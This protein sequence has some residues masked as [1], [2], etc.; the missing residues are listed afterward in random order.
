M[1]LT[2]AVAIR[3]YEPPDL[4]VALGVINAAARSYRAFLPP[5]HYHDPLM[6]PEDLRREAARVRFYVAVDPK[7]EVVGV[8]GLER[9]GDVALIRH[10]YVRPDRQR[11]GIGEALL[12]HLEGLVPAGTRIYIGT[13]RENRVARGHLAK[14]GYREV[15]DSDSILRTYYEIPEAQ[16]RG[17]IAFEKVPSGPSPSR[18]SPSRGEG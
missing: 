7:G 15:A 16:R 9:V 3:A 2:A 17:S 11:Q 1:A 13:Y 10:G 5:E 8:M 4:P 18:P 12:A 6:T 14:H